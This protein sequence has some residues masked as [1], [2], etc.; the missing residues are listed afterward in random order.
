MIFKVNLFDMSNLLPYY[1]QPWILLLSYS[2]NSMN[3]WRYDIDLYSLN[4]SQN[5]SS[6]DLLRP[7]HYGYTL[8]F[9]TLSRCI[10]CL[11]RW[12]KRICRLTNIFKIFWFQGPHMLVATKVWF[13]PFCLFLNYLQQQIY[14]LIFLKFRLFIWYLLSDWYL[15]IK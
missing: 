5:P 11:A 12:I 4:L 6:I 14:I 9:H 13:N 1:Q 15:T 7:W 3:V 2:A 10:K 8:N